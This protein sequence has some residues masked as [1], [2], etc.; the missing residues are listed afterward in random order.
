MPLIEDQF[1]TTD[2]N[3]LSLLRSLTATQNRLTY[4][5]TFCFR[6]LEE[7]SQPVTQDTYE[8]KI[9]LKSNCYI[10]KSYQNEKCFSQTVVSCTAEFIV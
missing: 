2:S 6:I 10:Y 9:A 8:Q 5:Q 1:A 7:L 3:R 4:R